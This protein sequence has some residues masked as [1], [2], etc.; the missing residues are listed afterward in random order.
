MKYKNEIISKMRKG[1]SNESKIKAKRCNSNIMIISGGDV[2]KLT[3]LWQ[4]T[5]EIRPVV[6]L[7]KDVYKDG[8]EWKIEQ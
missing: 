5:P 1:K 4:K 8:E 6:T 2:D 3:I 7:T